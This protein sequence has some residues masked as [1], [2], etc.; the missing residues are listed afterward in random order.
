MFIDYIATDHVLNIRI[1]N[2]LVKLNTK[3]CIT[4]IFIM[5][6]AINVEFI[7]ESSV[8][9]DKKR[10]K[11]EFTTKLTCA[12]D[13]VVSK[14]DICPNMNQLSAQISWLYL[15]ELYAGECYITNVERILPAATN[16]GLDLLVNAA[17]KKIAGMA[18]GKAAPV[19]KAFMVTLYVDGPHWNAGIQPVYDEYLVFKP[20]DEILSPGGVDVLR[21]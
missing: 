7:M 10:L 19:T 9:L 14:L 2:S 5:R 18:D 16:T 21:R 20:M 4:S 17:I 8:I 1:Q 3:Y 12:V 13:L 6:N 15:D 11:K